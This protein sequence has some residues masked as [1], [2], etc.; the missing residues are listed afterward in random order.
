MDEA[1]LLGDRI[2]IISKGKLCCCGSPLFLKSKLGSG[3][4]L[5][6]VKREELSTSTPSNSSICTSASTSTNKL[7]SLVKVCL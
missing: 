2:A 5:T 1:E 3:Y 4:Y 6:V 7:P